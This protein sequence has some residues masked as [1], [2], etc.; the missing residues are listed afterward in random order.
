MP[1]WSAKNHQTSMEN[2]TDDLDYNN[3]IVD[4]KKEKIGLFHTC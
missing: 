3:S 2:L 4:D 1:S